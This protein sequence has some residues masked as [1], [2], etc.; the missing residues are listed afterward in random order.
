MLECGW[1][2]HSVDWIYTDYLS[3][4]DSLGLTVRDTVL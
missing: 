2:P 3:N 1:G 4:T